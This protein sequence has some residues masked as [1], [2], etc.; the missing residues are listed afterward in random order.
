MAMKSTK[1]CPLPLTLIQGSFKVNH[2]AVL[3]NKPDLLVVEM[4]CAE[5]YLD[6]FE[7][8]ATDNT[9]GVVLMES[10]R[11][12]W[13]KGNPRP[14]SLT[15]TKLVLK[16][17]ASKTHVWRAECIAGR[18]TIRVLFYRTPRRA[19]NGMTLPSRKPRSKTEIPIV[20]ESIS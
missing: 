15:W 20:V 18:Y 5:K 3:V 6:C 7:G 19:R 8:A 10:D 16:H 11:T 4:D 13:S 14:K 2:L 1:K 17:P 12:L 9:L